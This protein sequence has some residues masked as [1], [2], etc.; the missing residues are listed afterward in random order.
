[1]PPF[2]IISNILLQEFLLP[3]LKRLVCQFRGFGFHEKTVS[4]IGNNS[5]TKVEIVA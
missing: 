3:Y 4:L 5:F 1:M 2:T